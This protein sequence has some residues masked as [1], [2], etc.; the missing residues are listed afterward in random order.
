MRLSQALM[1][2]EIQVDQTAISQWER[3]RTKPSA[4]QCIKLLG[5]AA[6]GEERAPILELLKREYDLSPSEYAFFTPTGT[7]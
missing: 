1:A 6:K 4:Q 2:K 7:E 3:G 5:L